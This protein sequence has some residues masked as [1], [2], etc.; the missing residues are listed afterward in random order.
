M[1]SRKPGAVQLIVTHGPVLCFQLGT[2]N[3]SKEKISRHKYKQYS[4]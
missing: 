1:G 4:R 3:F 2:P